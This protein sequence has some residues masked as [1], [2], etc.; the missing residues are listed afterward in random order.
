MPDFE[1]SLFENTKDNILVCAH[2]GL[3]GGNV[4]C[5]TLPAFKFALSQ[6][7]DIIEL[8]VEKSR[9]GELF[10]FHPGKER[11]HLGARI[12]L[13]RR[14]AESIKRLRYIN[15]DNEKTSYGV[16]RFEDVLLYLKGKCYINVD[17]FWRNIPEIS[18]VIR[19]CGVENQVIVKAPAKEQSLKLLEEY[20]PE[21]MYMP[22]IRRVDRITD[23][24][25]ERKINYVGAEVLFELETDPVG[26]KEYFDSMHQKGLVV[27]KNSIVYDEKAVISAGY[28]DDLAMAGLADESWGKLIESGADIIQTDFCPQLKAYIRS[29]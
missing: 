3:F 22:V 7:A 29:R 10:V 17:K 16:E 6:G 20:A 8:D 18:S 23:K 25:L 14:S 15:Y 13:K 27:F 19:K 1:K 9:D 24:L 26:T 2:R 21:F 5:N 4:P 28:T 12:P 11:A